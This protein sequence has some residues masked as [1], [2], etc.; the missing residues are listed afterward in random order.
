MSAGLAGILFWLSVASC[1][2]AEAAIIRAT[3]RV[4]R[5]SATEASALLPH[6]RRWLEIVWVI[7]PAIV[8]VVLLASTWRV[9]DAPRNDT[10]LFPA[11]PPSTTP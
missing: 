11:T 2:V 6:P 7:L 3:L 10:R 9:I 1:L 8:L 4:S 5:A